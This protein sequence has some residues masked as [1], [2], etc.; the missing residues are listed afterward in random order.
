MA[1]FTG[2]SIK[3]DQSS[4]TR[5]NRVVDTYLTPRLLSFRQL[6]MYDEPATLMPDALSWKVSFGNWNEDFI[7]EC[8]KNG[9]LLPSASVTNISVVNGTFRVGSPDLDTGGAPRDEVTLTYQFDYFPISILEGLLK[10]VVQIVN[11]GAV[12]PPTAHTIDTAPDN[13]DGVLS[14][15][16]YAM[17]IERLLLDYDLW[18]YRLI[19]AITPQDMEGGGSDIAQQ[20]ETLKQNAEERAYRTMEN[21]KFKVGNYISVPTI[22]YFDSI[23]GLSSGGRHGIPFS[24]GRLRGWVPN[25]IL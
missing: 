4:S 23:R 10:N 20:L 2:T 8:R 17:A 1:N 9:Q 5:I 19:F 22:H 12:G 25:R 21:E 16:A 13:W 24:S 14:D 11:T 7:V 3:I 15:L 6:F 18:R